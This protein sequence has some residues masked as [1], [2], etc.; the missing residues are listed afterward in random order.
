MTTARGGLRVGLAHAAY[1]ALLLVVSLAVGVVW[2]VRRALSGGLDADARA[3]ALGRFGLGAAA[4]PAVAASRPLWVH[5]VSVGEVAACAVLV[6]ALSERGP[7]VVSTSTPT[8]LAAARKRFGAERVFVAPID[9]GVVVARALRRVD[10]TALLL[11]ELEVW[12]T[13]LRLADRRGV[14]C[15]VVNGRVTERSARRYARLAWWVPE[16]DRLSLVAAQDDAIAARFVA[17]GVPPERV[18]VVGNLKHEGTRAPDST[19]VARLAADLGAADGG[20]V[21]VAGSTRT[22]E[23]EPLVDLWR[24]AV[25]HAPTLALVLVPRHPPRV[26][27]VVALVRAAGHDVTLRSELSAERPWDRRTVLVVDTIGELGALYALA[28]VAFVGGTLVEIGGHNVLEPAAAGAPQVVGPHVA[29]CRHEVE[30]LADQGLLAIVEGAADGASRVV[31]M[32][33]DDAREARRKQAAAFV[34]GLAGAT[35][36]HLRVLAPLLAER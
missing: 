25:E 11:V 28:D 15:A 12:P 34:A 33:G 31:E 14:P 24:R 16:F 27:D 5:A 7:V 2:V 9:L 1:Q 10:P 29:N 23:D 6:D 20:Q 35:E 17:L 4:R 22:G 18:H 36:A 13:W 3:W 19:A 32:L 21:F 8:G 30:L 26:P